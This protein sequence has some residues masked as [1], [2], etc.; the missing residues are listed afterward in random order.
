MPARRFACRGLRWPLKQITRISASRPSPIWSFLMRS[1]GTLCAPLGCPLCAYS[2]ADR[3]SMSLAPRSLRVN[4]S[5][6]AMVGTDA[7]P[8]APPAPLGL[9]GHIVVPG[10][11]DDAVVELGAALAS[12]ERLFDSDGG[13]GRGAGCAARAPRAKWPHCGAGA[14]RRRCRRALRTGR[15][16]PS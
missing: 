8:A 1:G 14:A 12:R 10:L 6:T 4:A 7:G 2:R 16:T 11:L 9:N 13:D 5:L 15:C 3:T